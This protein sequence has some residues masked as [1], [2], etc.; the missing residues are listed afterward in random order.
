MNIS[1]RY[2][3]LSFQSS[4][5]FYFKKNISL[6][7]EIENGKVHQKFVS[8]FIT[9]MSAAKIFCPIYGPKNSEMIEISDFYSI[10]LIIG[11]FDWF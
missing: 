10:F 8:R 6:I 2:K 3:L 4:Q 7:L 5:N 11:Y 1:Y 9:K